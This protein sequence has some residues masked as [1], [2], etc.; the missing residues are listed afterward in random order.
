VAG[1]TLAVRTGYDAV[2]PHLSSD[3]FAS[4]ASDDGIVESIDTKN[5]VIKIRYADKPVE[6]LRDL[7]VP[8]PDPLV[9]R[10]KRDDTTFGILVPE[11]EI[12]AYPMGAIFSITKLTNVKIIDRL[13]CDTLDAIPDKDIIKKQHNLIYDFTHGRYK[14]LYYL[15]LKPLGTKLPGDLKGYSYADTY[16]P[17]SGSHLLQTRAAN[18][19]VGE[20]VKRGD[21][22]VYNSGF[23]VPDP[24][25]KQVTFKHGVTGTIALIDKSSNHEDACEI[26]QDMS[27]RLMMTPSHQR[28]VVTKNDAAV[29]QIVKVGDHVETSDSLCIISSEDLVGSGSLQIENLDIMEKLNRQ[30]PLAGYTG[31]IV[32]IRLLYSCARDDLSESLKTLLKTYER[33]VRQSFDA[34]NTDPTVRAPEKPGYIEP[35]TKYQGVQ[36]GVDTVMLE[37]MVSETLGVGPGDKLVLGNAAKSIVSLVN[38]KSHYTETGIPVDILFSTTSVLGRIISSPLSVGMAERSMEALR[39][40]VVDLYFE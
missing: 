37:F 16:S 9:D 32:K 34:L 30:T 40:K 27:D 26:S 5:K 2:L 7:K 11:T 25:N 6:T 31:T 19:S 1:E 35:G 13:R 38:E 3:L 33:E 39:A 4:S 22:V 12:G 14:A 28:T 18:V 20:K 8:Y 17:I 15:R 23:F 10:Y 36:F 29:L 21:I 24:L